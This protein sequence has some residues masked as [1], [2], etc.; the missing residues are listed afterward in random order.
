[1]IEAISLTKHYHDSVAVEDASFVVKK[2]RV[3]GFIGPNG[4]GKSTTMKMILGLVRPTS[5]CALVNGSPYKDL[6]VPIKTVGSLLEPTFL[7]PGMTI[8]SHLRAI[9]VKYRI[10]ETKINGLLALVGLA[11]KGKLRCSKASL[12]MKQRL[13]IAQALLGDPAVLILDEPMNGLDP[14]GIIWFRNLLKDMAG[15]GKCIFVSSHLMNEMSLLID[16]VVI[17]KNGAVVANSSLS[18]LAK[19]H[20]NPCLEVAAADN[21]ALVGLLKDHYRETFNDNV[22]F[23]GNDLLQVAGKDARWLAELALKNNITVVHLA[24]KEN[25]LEEIYAGLMNDNFLCDPL[26]KM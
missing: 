23:L 4:S 7:H 6:P 9:A 20:S 1:M 3:T 15:E 10:P 5:G 26:S 13:G 25:T 17:I 14:E 11:D 18:D 24:V 2:G 22:S 21:S 12:G 16:D 8:F 19:E